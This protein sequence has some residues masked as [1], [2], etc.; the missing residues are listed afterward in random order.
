M[1]LTIFVHLHLERC[2]VLVHFSEVPFETFLV[3]HWMLYE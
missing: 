2:N 3:K 1:Q